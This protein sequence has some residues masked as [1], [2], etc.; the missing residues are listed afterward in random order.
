MKFDRPVPWPVRLILTGVHT[1]PGAIISVVACVI[2]AG[3][4]W[5][6]NAPVWSGVLLLAALA[7]GGA[8]VWMDRNDGW[9]GRGPS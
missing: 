2:F 1:R 7:Y 4:A 8:L 6:W 3:L 5:M 9:P